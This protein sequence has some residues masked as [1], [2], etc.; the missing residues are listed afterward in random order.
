MNKTKEMCILCLCVCVTFSL[1]LFFLLVK[2]RHTSSE[3]E[4]SSTG[5][6]ASR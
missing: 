1:F 4:G 6:Q 3:E 2:S 5:K